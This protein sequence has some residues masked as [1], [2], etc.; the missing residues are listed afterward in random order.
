MNKSGVSLISLISDEMDESSGLD[1]NSCEQVVY[2][3][4][5]VPGVSY[6]NDGEGRT[7][8]KKKCPC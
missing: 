1:L 7:P 4:H 6:V 3:V 2:E 8:V 5:D